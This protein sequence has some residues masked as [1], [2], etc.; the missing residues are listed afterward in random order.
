MN[1]Q[2]AIAA[3]EKLGF[4]N[5]SIEKIGWVH[6]VEA[7]VAG[8]RVGAAHP[9][10]D[11]AFARVADDG[12]KL[13]ASLYN[14]TRIGAVERAAVTPPAGAAALEDAALGAR[15]G[16]ELAAELAADAEDAS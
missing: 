1:I 3:F 12:V 9:V 5:V 10:L 15:D 8:L 7:E 16:G 2:E 11:E 14:A 6:V 4:V 13:R